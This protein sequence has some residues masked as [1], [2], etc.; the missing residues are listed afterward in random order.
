MLF[1]SA[2]ERSGLIRR[3]DQ[4]GSRSML[5]RPLSVVVSG[6]RYGC[7]MSLLVDAPPGVGALEALEA[8]PI[9]VL[10]AREL[11]YVL[12]SVAGL[13]GRLDAVDA[14]AL[15]AFARLGGAQDEGATDTTAWLAAATKTS[16]R[17]A[18]R[19]VKRAGV[20]EQ[21]PA[22]GAALAAGEVS[23]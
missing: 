10:S 9:E 8:L 7:C 13:R 4:R 1:F 12:R 20:I 21:L 17:D 15:A 14:R 11:S 19:A 23:A 22:L 18:K 16:A 6:R 2:S 3:S 5:V